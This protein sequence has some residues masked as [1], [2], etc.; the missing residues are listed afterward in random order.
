MTRRFPFP[1]ALVLVLVMAVA[2][3]SQAP[4]ERLGKARAALEQAELEGAAEYSPEQLAAT[5]ESL[6]LAEAE[7]DQQLRRFALLRSYATAGDLAD[8]A[9]F[10]AGETLKATRV[11]REAVRQNLEARLAQ[12]GSELERARAV[13]AKLEACRLTPRG[14]AI[15]LEESR[16]WLGASD[17][18]L[19]EI[20][21]KHEG[22]DDLTA[23][24][25]LDSAAEDLA[26][27]LRKLESAASD[28]GC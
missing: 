17:E 16:M 27:T 6:R 21:K 7:I 10:R 2:A 18:G 19:R 3:C 13:L 1:F 11:A 23:L 22:G 12:F 5:R 20:R 15:D 25:D 14:P 9:I 24:K 8:D 4:D 28:A 26:R